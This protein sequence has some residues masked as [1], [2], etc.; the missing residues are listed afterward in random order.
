MDGEGGT[1]GEDCGHIGVCV[2]EVMG[3]SSVKYFV[4][5]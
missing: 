2:K 1:V 3:F 4:E 5:E